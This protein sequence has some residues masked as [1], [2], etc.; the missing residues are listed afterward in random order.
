M[1]ELFLLDSVIL[2]DHLN[3]CPQPGR[4]GNGFIVAH[5][6]E[7]SRWANQHLP[8]LHGLAVQP[9]RANWSSIKIVEE[10]QILVRPERKPVGRYKLESPPKNN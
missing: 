1:K 6:F 8:T 9:T 3:Q 2:I 5:H 7:L 10:N 4:V